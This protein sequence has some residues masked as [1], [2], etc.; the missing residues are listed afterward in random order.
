MATRRKTPKRVIAKSKA[1]L[2]QLERQKLE[3]VWGKSRMQRPSPPQSASGFRVGAKKQG[4][5]GNFYV[6]L[7]DRTGRH[8]WARVRPKP[9]SVARRKRSPSQREKQAPGPAERRQRKYTRLATEWAR[10]HPRVLQAMTTAP[11]ERSSTLSR[12]VLVSRIRVLRDGWEGMT[13]RN[14]DLSDERLAEETLAE[15]RQHYDW[16]YSAEAQKL[17]AEWLGTD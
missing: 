4:N 14:H 13:T 7:A 3:N 5:D 15:L 8:R 11:A 17:I 6:I 10:Q 1:K 2:R 12:D 9:R 16:F